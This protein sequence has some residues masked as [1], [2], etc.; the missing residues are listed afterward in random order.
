MSHWSIKS[1]SKSLSPSWSQWYLWQQT[2][3]PTW[4]AL[5]GIRGVLGGQVSKKLATTCNPNLLDLLSKWSIQMRCLPMITQFP[6]SS[7][8][9]YPWCSFH[10]HPE[11]TSDHR[12]SG[13][14]M[15]GSSTHAELQILMACLLISTVDV[16]VDVSII[17]CDLS[18][19]IHLILL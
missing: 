7:K 19:S 12:N 3:S 6:L 10:F 4:V 14:I 15:T 5:V 2:L 17:W 13:R 8:W 1:H 11:A 9:W 18:K 16:N